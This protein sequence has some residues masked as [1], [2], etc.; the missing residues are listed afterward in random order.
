MGSGL[1]SSASVILAMLRG[2]A[3]WHKIPLSLSDYQRIATQLEDFAHGKSSGLDVSAILQEGIHW[4]ENGQA[5]ALTIP[6]LQGYLIDT[7]STQSSTA[8]CV[9]HVRQYHAQNHQLWTEMRQQVETLKHALQTEQTPTMPIN[10]LQALLTSLGV[11]PAKV[12][13]FT[14]QIESLGWAGKQCGAGSIQGDGGGFYWL[15]ADSSPA[16]IC[17]EFNYPYWSLYDVSSQA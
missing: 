1:G 8:D 16:E 17:Q 2:L 11:V 14:H 3:E 4:W 12:Q 10:A 15:L 9:R 5:E 7:G 6:S 13:A